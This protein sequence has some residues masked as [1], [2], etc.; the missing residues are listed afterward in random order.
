MRTA[1]GKRQEVKV[2][3]VQSVSRVAAARPIRFLRER[4]EAELQTQ[5]QEATGACCSTWRWGGGG[6]WGVGHA[7]L[8]VAE[9]RS[10]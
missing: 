4:E 1:L 7:L 5:V 6:G 9:V 10:N 3:E 8:L 2:E